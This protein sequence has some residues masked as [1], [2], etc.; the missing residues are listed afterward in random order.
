M[1]ICSKL[2]FLMHICWWFAGYPMSYYLSHLT[3][4]LPIVVMVQKIGRRGG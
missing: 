2:G 1:G 3:L 4:G